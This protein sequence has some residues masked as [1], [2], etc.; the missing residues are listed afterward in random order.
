MTLT[1]LQQVVFQARQILEKEPWF[2]GVCLDDLPTNAEIEADFDACVDRI[3]FA[4]EMWDGPP[5]PMGAQL[6]APE[7]SKTM[8][9]TITLE[10]PDDMTKEEVHQGL[11]QAGWEYLD[12]RSL[13]DNERFLAASLIECNPSDAQYAAQIKDQA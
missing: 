10:V 1:P 5:P 3:V 13:S 2:R 12:C 9:I 6:P 7:R 11:S 4:T 8:K